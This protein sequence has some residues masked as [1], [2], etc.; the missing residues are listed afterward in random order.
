MNRRTFFELAGMAAS[1]LLAQTVETAR[2]GVGPLKITKIDALVIRTPGDNPAPESLA[3]MT[4][5][6]AM[7]GGAGR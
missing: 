5:L 3:T 1:P 7:T 6:G 4:P 2:R